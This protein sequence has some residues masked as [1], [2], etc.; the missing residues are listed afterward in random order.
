MSKLLKFNKIYFSLAVLLFAIEVLIAL[1]AHDDV[2]RPYV[3][4][5]LVVILIYC[6][7]KSFFDTPVL[8]TALFVLLFA[9]VVEGLQYLN[10]LNRLGL[11]DSKI[12]AVIIGSS[13]SCIDIITYIIGIGFVLFF[14]KIVLRKDLI[15]NAKSD[16]V[17]SV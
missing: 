8:K 9:F 15:G 1:F 17:N 3:G 10:I 4:D 6:F 14:E 5:V 13:F 12:A 2:I 11:K 16:N 7:V